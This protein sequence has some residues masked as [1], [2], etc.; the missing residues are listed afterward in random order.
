MHV[1]S[2]FSEI[3]CYRLISYS[4]KWFKLPYVS[5]GEYLGN[6]VNIKVVAELLVFIVRELRRALLY[7]APCC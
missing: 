7:L 1:P 6:V 4:S 5:G 3:K 2:I